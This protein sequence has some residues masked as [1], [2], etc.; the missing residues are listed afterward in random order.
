MQVQNA[1]KCGKWTSIDCIKGGQLRSPNCEWC[2]IM[3]IKTVPSAL[4]WNVII[5]SFCTSMVDKTAGATKCRLTLLSTFSCLLLADV[6]SEEAILKWYNESHLAKGK[7]VFLEQMKQFVEWLKNAE[8]GNRRRPHFPLQSARGPSLCA[9]DVDALSTQSPSRRRRR[10]TEDLSLQPPHSL[11]FLRQQQDQDA[12]ERFLNASLF[13]SF[14]LCSLP[15][16]ILINCNVRALISLLFSDQHL[17]SLFSEPEGKVNSF[18]QIVWSLY[19]QP[20]RCPIWQ[21]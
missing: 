14:P 5:Y 4:E 16:H 9:D 11:W 19:I 1:N 13:R 18:W 12:V 7:S 6:L 8:E 20:V 15:P 3:R 21:V 2:N 17:N 10:P